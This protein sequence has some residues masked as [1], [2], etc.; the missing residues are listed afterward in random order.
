MIY[1]DCKFFDIHLNF[2]PRLEPYPRLGPLIRKVIIYLTA[3]K[4]KG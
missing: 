2:V 1:L 3:K 4:R